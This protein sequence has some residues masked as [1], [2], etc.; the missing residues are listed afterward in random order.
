[1]DSVLQPSH[2]RGQMFYKVK[3]SLSPAEEEGGGGEGG[4][5]SWRILALSWL[6]LPEPSLMLSYVFSSCLL[7]SKSE[8]INYK[9]D[10]ID[11]LDVT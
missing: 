11:T 2:I 6:N 8:E 1:M 5:G 9:I 10:G 3:L 7:L 4:R